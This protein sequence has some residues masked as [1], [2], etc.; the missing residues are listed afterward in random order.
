MTV[1]D[2][3]LTEIKE[4][5]IKWL[6]LDPTIFNL[7]NPV[8]NQK[9]QEL[10]LTEILFGTPD[11]K[12]WSA[13]LP[14]FACVANSDNLV[15]SD[16]FFGSVEGDELTSDYVIVNLEVSFICQAALGEDTERQFDY[17]HKKIR[18]RLKSNVRIKN[19]IDDQSSASYGTLVNGTELVATS[20]TTTSRIFYVLPGNN[21]RLIGC[22]IGFQL[23]IGAQ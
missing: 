2:F 3:D 21:T 1:T 22:A 11:D 23:E 20:R 10:K 9:D 17:L 12:Q 6:K 16:S 19:S 18:E 7:K 15:Q 8:G 14:P 5:I 13:V 4:R